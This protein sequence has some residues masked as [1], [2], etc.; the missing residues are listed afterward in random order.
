MLPIYGNSP[1]LMECLLSIEE[2]VGAGSKLLVIDDGV[3]ESMLGN[4]YQWININ[5]KQQNISITTNSINLG[6]FES[7]NRNIDCIQTSWYCFICSDDVFLRGSAAVV[8]DIRPSSK[9]G[10]VLSKFRS[11]NHDGSSRYDDC[12]HLYQRITKFGATLSPQQMIPALLK[13]GSFN[14]N[15]SGM[16]ISKALWEQAGPF[17][18]SWKHAADWDWLITAGGI[19]TTLIN[20]VE[21]VAVRTHSN[22]LSN[23]NR[24]NGSTLT[25]SARVV[26]R[27]R[28]H[29][30]LAS[31]PLTLWWSAQIMQHHLWNILFNRSTRRIFIYWLIKIQK[32]SQLS[33]VLIA[34]F[35]SIPGRIHR[36]IMMKLNAR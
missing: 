21:I 13:F 20:E 7:L 26:T 29:P 5:E 25:E 24:F 10:L 35:A 14:G 2:F 23:A 27:L 15:L 1:Y 17:N 30:L 12:R 28:A 3:S 22:Q 8:N 11:I 18:S 9:V 19:T 31:N 33:I 36:R 34:L 4:L 16:I 6:L 32:A